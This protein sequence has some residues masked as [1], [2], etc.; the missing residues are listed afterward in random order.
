VTRR[1]SYRDYLTK[2]ELAIIRVEEQ[3][4]RAA[5]KTR[6]AAARARRKIVQRATKRMHR[7]TMGEK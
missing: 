3:A 6:A 2:D 5:S 4:F 1:R 7:K